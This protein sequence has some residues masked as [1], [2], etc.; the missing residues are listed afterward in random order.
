MKKKILVVGGMLCLALG[1]CACNSGD[2]AIDKVTDEVT[3][4][5]EATEKVED[6][7]N[8]ALKKLGF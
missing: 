7:V 4:I 8:G 3:T 5:E 2:K 1:L 6:A